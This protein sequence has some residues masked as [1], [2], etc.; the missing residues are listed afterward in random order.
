MSFM[1]LGVGSFNLFVGL[2]CALRQ[3]HNPNGLD[4]VFAAANITLAVVMF[5]RWIVLDVL[6]FERT[7]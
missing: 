6:P 3:P 7:R 2:L 4:E 5:A 1:R